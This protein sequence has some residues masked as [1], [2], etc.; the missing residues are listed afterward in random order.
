MKR[1]VDCT[2][3]HR[4]TM[5]DLEYCEVCG[6]VRVLLCGDWNRWGADGYTLYIYGEQWQFATFLAAYRFLSTQKWAQGKHCSIS[7]TRTGLSIM[8]VDSVVRDALMG[9]AS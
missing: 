1:R 5:G 8:P 6:H 7:D 4:V 9:G 3:G 2:H